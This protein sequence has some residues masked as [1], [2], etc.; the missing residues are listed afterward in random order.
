MLNM[1]TF[2]RDGVRSVSR[3]RPTGESYYQLLDEAIELYLRRNGMSQASLAKEMGMAENTF[4]WKR[5]GVR[6]FTLKEAAHLCD[7]TGISLDKVIGMEV[8]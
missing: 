6:E 2:E 5:R 7:L 8:A 4:S 3:N 1:I